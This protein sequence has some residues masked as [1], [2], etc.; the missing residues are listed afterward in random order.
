MSIHKRILHWQAEHPNITWAF[1]IVVW[2]IVLFLL[3]WPQKSA[4]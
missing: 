1:W 2:S 4:L 3:F